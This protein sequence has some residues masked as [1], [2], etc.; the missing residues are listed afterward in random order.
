MKKQGAEISLETKLSPE[1]RLS[2]G[3]S[4]LKM[5]SKAGSAANY[6]ADVTNPQPN[7]YRLGVNYA[8][9]AWDVSLNLTGATGRSLER[10]SSSS[11][12]VLD[13]AV[14][15]KIDK[16]AKLYF[17]WNNIT[18]QAYEVWGNSSIGNFPMPASNWQIGL[19]YSF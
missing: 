5:E 7:G 14:N 18:N 17:K 2:A 1:W 19:K 8:Q 3:Y 15:Y 10:F 9:K 12:W 13:L 4:W 11:Y 16:N 6:V